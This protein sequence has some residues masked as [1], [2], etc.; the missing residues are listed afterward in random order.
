M[1]TVSLTLR[2]IVPFGST[3]ESSKYNV[4][5]TNNGDI[6]PGS[7][8]TIGLNGAG[9]ISRTGSASTSFV[10]TLGSVAQLMT[11]EIQGI[12]GVSGTAPAVQYNEMKVTFT[13]L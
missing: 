11:F 6:V 9:M 4:R 3:A 8:M 7:Y 5:L 13:E 2:D 12:L 10:M 1:C